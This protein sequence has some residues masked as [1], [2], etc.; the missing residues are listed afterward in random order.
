M[1]HYRQEV[2]RYSI[3]LQTSVLMVYSD[4]AQAAYILDRMTQ[5]VSLPGETILP[6]AALQQLPDLQPMPGKFGGFGLRALVN[7]R[8]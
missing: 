2:Y 1:Q 8:F 6:S 7:T 3:A 5:A 4:V